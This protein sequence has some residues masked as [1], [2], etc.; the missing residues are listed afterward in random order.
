ME[1]LE[2]RQILC[3]RCQAAIKDL[4]DAKNG[5]KYS[6]CEDELIRDVCF[7][8]FTAVAPKCHE[9]PSAE[10]LKESDFDAEDEAA[11]AANPSESGS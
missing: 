7:S 2:S 11:A 5:G 4:E 8:G 6:T 10:P 9:C 1:S 3:C